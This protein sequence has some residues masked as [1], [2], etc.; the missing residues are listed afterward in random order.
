MDKTNKEIML[1]CIEQVHNQ[2]R[3]ERVDDYYS[4]DCMFHGTPF[5]GSGIRTDQLKMPGKHLVADIL[6][7]GPAAGKLQAGDELLNV[8]DG[9]TTWSTFEELKT[10]DWAYGPVGSPLVYHVRRG[11]QELDV[12][13]TRGL[14]EGFDLPF[15]DLKPQWVSFLVEEC[16]DFHF[17]AQ[18]AFE[19]GDMVVLYGLNSGTSKEYQKFAIWPSCDIYRLREGKVVDMWNV[20]DS[21]SMLAQLGY[22]LEAPKQAAASAAEP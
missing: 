3:V 1:D 6:P 18:M 21:R 17:E 5:V 13:V 22:H 16:P 8:S 10:G 11:D 7:G 4:P 15:S 19:D 20:E 12:T 9:R 14:V 2:K